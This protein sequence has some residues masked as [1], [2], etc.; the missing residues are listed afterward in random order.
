MK[1][2]VMTIGLLMTFIGMI[3]NCL[4]GD[5]NRNLI[6]YE[7]ENKE[8]NKGKQ[9]QNDTELYYLFNQRL[10]AGTLS[11]SGVVLIAIGF[12]LITCYNYFNELIN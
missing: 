11:Y 12:L 8:K 10:Q 7:K 1:H 2:V 5:I 3:L 6:I 9:N 4:A